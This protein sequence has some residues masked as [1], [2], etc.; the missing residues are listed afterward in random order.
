MNKFIHLNFIRLL[1]LS[2]LCILNAQAF[3]NTIK[4][5]DSYNYKSIDITE[6]IRIFSDP[7]SKNYKEIINLKHQFKIHKKKE[8]KQNYTKSSLWINFKIHNDLNRE[9]EKVLYL[10]STMSGELELNVFSNEG[11]FIYSD[12]SGNSITY[13]QKQIPSL[14]PSFK[15]II[16]PNQTLDIFLKRTSRHRLDTK[17]FISNTEVFESIDLQK[18]FLLIF[19]LGAIIAITLYNFIVLLYTR[20]SVYLYYC[21]FAT[22]LALLVLNLNGALDYFIRPEVINFSKYTL[23][24]SS[25]A[26]LFTILFAFN[27]LKISKLNN[28][29]KNI[30]LALMSVA[31]LHIALVF[32]PLF[33][34]MSHILG[35]SIDLSI[36]VSLLAILIITT[37]CVYK[38]QLMAK[39]YLASFLF[40]FSGVAIWFGMNIGIFPANIITMN[41][42]LIANILEMI[43]IAI[44]L[45]YKITY[46]DKKEEQVKKE[47]LQ[48]Q[49]YLRLVRVLSHD[50]SN[51]LFII[52][53]FSKKVKRDPEVIN[54]IEIWN[55]ISR[56][57]EN[58]SKILHQV[59]TEINNKEIINLE[60]QDIQIQKIINESIFTFEAKCREKKIKIENKV[61]ANTFIY[62]E[63]TALLNNVVNNIIS[64][65]IKFSRESSVIEISCTSSKTH[66]II[67]FKDS[68]VGI[69]QEEISQYLKSQF[70]TTKVGTRGEEGTGHGMHLLHNY[71]EQF[72]GHV[73]IDSISEQNDM[74]KSGTTVKLYFPILSPN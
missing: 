63:P 21:L 70:I 22:G 60:L 11:K 45:A 66:K 61:T 42:L 32:T 69:T 20:D 36:A 13:G 16:K 33:E 59:R 51:S 3:D 62:A 2:T 57:S 34:P 47:A 19:Y 43:T 54:K 58:I 72:G 9:V 14:A 46:I 68:G 15:I 31:I 65:A 24:F 12:I 27:F 38:K 1:I 10:T 18:K 52:T 4:I 49:K 71:M 41:S 8:L 56:A 6:K 48:H 53:G 39:F 7:Q 55:K 37:F 26:L 30:F 5:S 73:E 50:I 25:F 23:L 64:N 74:E 44:G 17:I 40:I 29:F 67:L 28:N 35:V